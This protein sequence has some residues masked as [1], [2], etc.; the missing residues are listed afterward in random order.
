MRDFNGHQIYNP[1][2]ALP[3]ILSDTDRYDMSR[4]KTGCAVIFNF[5]D[6]Q[7][8]KRY[9]KRIGSQRDVDRLIKVFGDLNID[10]GD[11]V[12][13]NM[14]YNSMQLRFKECKYLLLIK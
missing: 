2:L 14:T 6:F 8:Y 9:Q 12:Y 10:I 4:S 13:K 5:E 7:D 11:R 3:V 1:E